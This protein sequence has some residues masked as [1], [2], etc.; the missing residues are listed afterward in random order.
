MLLFLLFLLSPTVSAEYD[1]LTFNMSFLCGHPRQYTY[2]IT[3]NIRDKNPDKSIKSNAIGRVSAETNMG[4]TEVSVTGFLD[5]DPSLIP[6]WE[7][8]V[9]MKHNCQANPK[10]G[11]KNLH[12]QFAPSPALRNKTRYIYKYYMDITD[13]EGDLVVDAEI[14]KV[15]K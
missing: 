4:I 2:D 15:S 9:E 14:S 7:P 10:L 1:I 13:K 6:V 8:I 5:A 11:Y 3:F 12:L